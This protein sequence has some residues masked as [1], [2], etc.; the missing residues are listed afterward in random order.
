MNE[1]LSKAADEAVPIPFGF[2]IAGHVA[3]T[4]TSLRIDD[5]YAV[6]KIRY[7]VTPLS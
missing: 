4:K 6:K 3:Q 5:V 7:I 2:G 1:A